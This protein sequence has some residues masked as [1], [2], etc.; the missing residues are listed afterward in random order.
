MADNRTF[1]NKPK[2]LLAQM[3]EMKS[4]STGHNYFSG[5]IGNVRLVMFRDRDFEIDLSKPSILDRWNVFVEEAPS[6]S[7]TTAR[8]GG[9][10]P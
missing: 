9:G 2:V 4:Q 8:S 3:L 7:R 5:F 1:E 6:K 10:K